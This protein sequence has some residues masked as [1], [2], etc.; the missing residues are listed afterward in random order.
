M[1]ANTIDLKARAQQ[2]EASIVAFSNAHA[3]A[4][5]RMEEAQEQQK[6]AEFKK[7][8]VG[9]T[10]YDRFICSHDTVLS[11][12]VI[13]R[14]ASTITIVGVGGSE[15]WTRQKPKRCRIMKCS[16]EVYGCE[17]ISPLGNYSMSPTLTADR[18]FA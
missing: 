1:K 7:F 2:L 17:A 3:E 15:H 6:K 5:K 4:M 10:Y 16:Y 13:A 9:K 8:E 14:T 18:D 12:K 11:F